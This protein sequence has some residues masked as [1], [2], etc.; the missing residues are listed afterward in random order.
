[1]QAKQRDEGSATSWRAAG[2]QLVPPVLD[3]LPDIECFYWRMLRL[4]R[5][6]QGK[7]ARILKNLQHVLSS[8]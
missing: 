4:R 6:E 3:V 1:M 2:V 8:N 5:H 7:K